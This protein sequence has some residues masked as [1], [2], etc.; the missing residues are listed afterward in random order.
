MSAN[1]K[2]VRQA[3]ASLLTTNLAGSGLPLQEL[4]RYQVGD[5]GGQS[6]VA[7]LTSAG[8]RRERLTFQGSKATFFFDLHLFVLYAEPAAD[9]NEENAEDALDD[10]EAEVAAL[11]DANQRTATWEALDYAERST[12]LPVVIGGAEYK[13]EIIPVSV[14]VFG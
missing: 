2:V 3:L 6:P 1:R 4:Y 12:A 14:E 7:V 11:L 5:F 9:W 10:I 8:T 13:H